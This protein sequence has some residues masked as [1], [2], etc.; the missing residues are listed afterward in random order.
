MV[1]KPHTDLLHST[2]PGDPYP[3][4]IFSTPRISDTFI[5]EQVAL[6]EKAVADKNAEEE[7]EAAAQAAAKER[8][9]AS[10]AA[11]R[12]A[13]QARVATQKQAQTHTPASRA[14]PHPAPARRPVGAAPKAMIPTRKIPGGQNLLANRQQ[15]HQ[16]PSQGTVKIATSAISA[17]AKLAISM[18]NNAT[19]QNIDAMQYDNS[20]N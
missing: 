3:E 8:A 14:T 16:G 15:Q 4:F 12:A 19:T 7:V 17:F 18:N 1:G 9:A 2:C 6:A 13:S 11:T 20:W 5:E 10:E